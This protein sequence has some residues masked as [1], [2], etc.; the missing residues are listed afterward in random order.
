VAGYMRE[1]TNTA[2]FGL[3]EIPLESGP[4]RDTVLIRDAEVE[5][6]MAPA[7]FQIDVSHDGRTAAVS[8]AYLACLNDDF[9]PEDCALFLVDLTDPKRK[10]TKVSIPMPSERPAIPALK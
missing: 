4:L 1:G 2:S 3:L 9:R 7:C 8:S 5:R 6:D 10:V